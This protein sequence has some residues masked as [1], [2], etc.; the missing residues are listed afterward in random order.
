M[1]YVADL[2][3]KGS[4]VVIVTGVDQLLSYTAL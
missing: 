3:G 4:V 2:M 1:I